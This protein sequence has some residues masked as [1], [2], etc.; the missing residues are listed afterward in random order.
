MD[1]KQRVDKVK[2]KAKVIAELANNPLWTQREIAEW[3]WVSLWTANAHISEVEQNWTKSLVIEEIINRDTQIMQ[4]WQKIIL[5]KMKSG[6]ISNRD[7]ISAI[8]TWAKRYTI[9]KWSATDKDWWLRSIQDLLL[10]NQNDIW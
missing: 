5:E 6:E 4:E 9:F 2:N 10:G 7:V 3:A 1:K 8:D